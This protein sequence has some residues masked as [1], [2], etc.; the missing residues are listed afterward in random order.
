[1]LDDWSSWMVGVFEGRSTGRSTSIC[2]SSRT[3]LRSMSR[4]LDCVVRAAF[5]P[6][7]VSRM[8]FSTAACASGRSASARFL[9]VRLIETSTRSRMI[10]STSRPWKPTSV[11]LVAS[12]LM[13]G[14]CA[15][16]D[17]RRA[18]SVFPTPVGPIIRMFFGTI[19]AFNS[20]PSNCRRHRFRNA[21]ATARFAAACPIMYLSSSPTIARGVSD[22]CSF[23][24]TAS[25][26]DATAVAS[27]FVS[28]AARDD[29]ARRR[30]DH[31][32]AASPS[33]APTPSRDRTLVRGPLLL[34]LLCR[35]AP[36][37]RHG[38]ASA[39]TRRAMRLT[40]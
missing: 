16:F 22:V 12:T 1:M 20:S 14:A 33:C 17:S 34:V 15:S 8:R 27:A 24:P 4:K 19:S 10:W 5:A 7:S 18:I 31:T 28:D 38:L 21:I 2:R 32:R 29:S 37:H 25:S 35:A 3:P 30:D 40:T 6:V 11:N 9:R 13:N 36:P 23:C 39:A 26:P